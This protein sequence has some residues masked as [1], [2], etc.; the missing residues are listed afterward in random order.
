MSSFGRFPPVTRR[1]NKTLAGISYADINISI[2]HAN[3]QAGAIG[4]AGGGDER[5]G[6]R[7]GRACMLKSH[8]GVLWTHYFS[9]SLQETQKV[10]VNASHVCLQPRGKAA[11][12]ERAK[13]HEGRGRK[14]VWRTATKAES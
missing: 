8:S 4:E 10:P 14:R 3:E 9:K 5:A 1:V 12:L 6:A 7:R 2:T 11:E 13:R